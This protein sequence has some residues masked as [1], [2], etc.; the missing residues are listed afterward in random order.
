MGSLPL[1]R[2]TLFHSSDLDY[3]HDRVARVLAPHSLE[4]VGDDAELNAKMHSRRLSD[5]G[6]SFLT[7]GGEVIFE[8]GSIDSYFAIQIP[9]AGVTDIECGG[10]RLVSTPET[11]AVI[12]PGDHLAMRW[13][14]GCAQ[15][16]CR[17]ERVALESHLASMLGEGLTERLRFD[18]AMDIIDGGSGAGVRRTIY[19]LVRRLDRADEVMEN[20][21]Y[22][23]QCEQLLMTELLLAQPHNYSQQLG[24]PR[25]ATSGQ[26][27]HAIDL[28]ESHPERSH[29]IL[30]LAKQV[31]VSARSLQRGFQQELGT[32]FQELLR[33][34]RL[35]RVHDELRAANPDTVT[36][37]EV[38]TRW[39][40]PLKGRSFEAYRKRYG[41]TP[42][43]TLRSSGGSWRDRA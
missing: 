43:T 10:H 36:V 25:P 5:I 1:E 30:G 12:S 22:V 39:G 9:L 33:E 2:F 34:I 6:I 42:L 28:L 17:I 31:S 18:L 11:A 8:S 23:R 26:L 32:T 35:R 27:R 14:D 3:V 19:D 40:L 21:W 41:E 7:Y 38:M 24:E 16:V 13:F 15:L 37:S 4:L 29:T 20:D